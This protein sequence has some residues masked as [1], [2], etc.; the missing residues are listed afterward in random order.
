MRKFT[1]RSAAITAAAVVAIGGGGAAW[2][3]ANGWDING[4]GTGDATAASINPLT[5]S[6]DMGTVVVYPGLQ[7]TVTSKVSNPNDFPVKLNTTAVTPT[8][9]T[10]TNGQTP[11]ECRTALLAAPATLEASFLYQPTIGKKLNNVDVSS[12][13]AI[14]NTFPQ[15]CA[16]T[17][18]KVFYTF[19]GVTAA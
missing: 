3:A 9:V 11:T 13:V 5:A 4:T 16:G 15:V 14:A 6:L 8:D 2:A 19:T 12:K 10:V 1:K 18:I 7:A 17:H